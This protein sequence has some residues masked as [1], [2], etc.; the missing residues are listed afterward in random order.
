MTQ[1]VAPSPF[2]IVTENYS[3]PV[4][5]FKAHFISNYN[6]RNVVMGHSSGRMTVVTF[7]QLPLDVALRILSTPV[8][9][10]NKDCFTLYAED[11]SRC[12]TVGFYEA[13][14]VLETATPLY[15]PKISHL[16]VDWV[17]NATVKQS[18]QLEEVFLPFAKRNGWNVVQSPNITNVKV[19]DVMAQIKADV[20]QKT[21]NSSDKYKGPAFKQYKAAIE[22]KRAKRA[23]EIL[24]SKHSLTLFN[25]KE[26]LTFNFGTMKNRV[27][28][29]METVKSDLSS[30]P[31]YIINAIACAGSFAL[32]A[33]GL[34]KRIP[35]EKRS[36]KEAARA[37]VKVSSKRGF[38]VGLQVGFQGY[39]HTHMMRK[40]FP[41]V[42]NGYDAYCTRLLASSAVVSLISVPMLEVLFS[43]NKRGTGAFEKFS[44]QKG[45]ACYG[46]QMIFMS[47]VVGI[48]PIVD[49]MQK[50]FGS[51]KSVEYASAGGLGAVGG[52]CCHLWDK[53][54][55]HL[56]N[57]KS[58]DATLKSRG[59]I[60]K[61]FF[62]VTFTTLYRGLR[63]Q[64]R[65][66]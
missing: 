40:G 17:T 28:Q 42:Q 37:M 61:T 7:Q 49:I 5:S 65:Q 1:A 52:V 47:T 12:K 32:V 56:S 20:Q 35:Q 3:G 14:D 51:H 45:V 9:S 43:N 16:N 19:N 10:T 59:L 24:A 8:R 62:M 55:S 26:D 29:S 36:F 18:A 41:E 11:L 22:I 2:E 21:K 66:E 27:Q 34:I 54:I 50:R 58:V 33:N 38:F 30:A 23:V 39:L 46:S 15:P 13:H 53:A 44:F 57:P 60:S 6:A 25:K 31:F 48:T 64:L 63:D 4:V